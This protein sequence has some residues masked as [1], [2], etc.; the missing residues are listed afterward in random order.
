MAPSRRRCYAIA[1][2]TAARLRYR[3]TSSS[4]GMGSPFAMAVFIASKRTGSI[5]SADRRCQDG[6][7]RSKSMGEHR[8]RWGVRTSNPGRVARRFLVGSTPILFRQ[9]KDANLRSALGEMSIRRESA[10]RHLDSR[11]SSESS[12]A[13]RRSKSHSQARFLPAPINCRDPD[14]AEVIDGRRAAR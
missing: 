14:A 5:C 2:T 11:Q 13:V 12:K 1:S 7:R 10:P 8:S 6:L 4:T 3:F 9:P